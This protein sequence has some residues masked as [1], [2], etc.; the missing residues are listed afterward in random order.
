[1]RAAV[2]EQPAQPDRY[3]DTVDRT[4]LGYQMDKGNAAS[5]VSWV[6]HCARPQRSAARSR[7]RSGGSVSGMG[8]V[9]HFTS[10]ESLA[11]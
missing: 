8:C 2:Q 6:D 1:M 3:N 9:G 11:V 4:G 10:L 7:R 5:G